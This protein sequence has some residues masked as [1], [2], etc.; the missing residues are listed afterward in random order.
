M[1]V[2]A[3]PAVTVPA[4]VTA[5]P[6]VPSPVP[7]MVPVMAPPHFLRLQLFH[8]GP[9]GDRGTDILIRGRQQPAFRKR[10]RRQWCCLRTGRDRGS[11]GGYS[12]G[13]FQKVTAFHDIS[14]FVRGE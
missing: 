3:M 2:P 13:D 1:A 7:V 6:V 10:L 11:T 4:P 14:F 9:A 5:V 12:N 8:L